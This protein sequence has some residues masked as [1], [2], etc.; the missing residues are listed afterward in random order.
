M[1]SQ[2]RVGTGALIWYILRHRYIELH[3]DQ[4]LEQ[5]LEAIEPDG[6]ARVRCERGTTLLG[7]FDTVVL[8]T[9]YQTDDDLYQG[10]LGRVPELYLVGDA[11]EPRSALEAIREAAEVA[12]KI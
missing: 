11:S 6:R 4:P 1:G 8:A 9:G 10:L 5:S 2:S 12:V 7:P 3:H